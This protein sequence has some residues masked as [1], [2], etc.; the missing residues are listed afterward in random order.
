MTP[1]SG[2][3]KKHRRSSPLVRIRVR[4][5]GAQCPASYNLLQ[6]PEL[7][8]VETVTR[9]LNSLVTGRRVRRLVIRDS[10]LVLPR[11]G[12]IEG[13]RIV[14]VRRSGKQV[15][16]DLAHGRRRRPALFLVAHLR[17]TGR[18]LWI[19]ERSSPPGRIR[20]ELLLDRGRVAFCDNRRFG[21]LSLFE[22]PQSVEPNGLEPLDNSLTPAR[23]TQLVA[24]SRQPIKPWLLRQDRL[25]GIGNIY[26]AEI[27]FASRIHPRRMAGSL[28]RDE[29]RGLLRAIR[30][31]LRRAIERGGTTFSDYQ[32][33]RGRS[34]S[35]AR[36]LKVY[37]R[38]GEPCRRCKGTIERMVQQ[39]RGT[40]YCPDCQ[41]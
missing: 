23:L 4:Y 7:P 21:T 35:F 18:L 30:T 14:K 29:T 12:R 31:V 33:S 19:P 3:R 17:M 24:R 16:F 26:A 8:E 20:A 41:R 28:T 6:M 1:F 36:L 34:G 9:Q 39:Q 22:T 37:G 11:I 32:D 27:L 2:F 15:V 10:K 13:A 40:F 25:V 38:A 5:S